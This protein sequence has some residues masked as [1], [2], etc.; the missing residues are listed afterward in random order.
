MCYSQGIQYGNSFG[1]NG[2]MAGRRLNFQ[3]R[4]VAKIKARARMKF[5]VDEPACSS[6][7]QVDI[8]MSSKNRCERWENMLKWRMKGTEDLLEEGTEGREV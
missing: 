1:S 5:R 7:F 3:T 6:R 2:R 4:H 8:V